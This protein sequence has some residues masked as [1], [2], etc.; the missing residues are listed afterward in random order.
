MKEVKFLP[1]GYRFLSIG[2]PIKTGDYF[3]NKQRQK[4]MKVHYPADTSNWIEKHLIRK[5]E[6]KK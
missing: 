5:D 4:W 6:D 2:E 3:W 1:E